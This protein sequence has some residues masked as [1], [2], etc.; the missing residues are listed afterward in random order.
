MTQIQH[1]I[2]NEL[3]KEIK[4]YNGWEGL[5]ENLD[6]LNQMSMNEIRNFLYDN[7]HHNFHFD[8]NQIESF[9]I[10]PS[11]KEMIKWIVNNLDNEKW[12]NWTRRFTM[13]DLI[14]KKLNRFR[15]RYE[16]FMKGDRVRIVKKRSGRFEDIEN[17][18]DKYYIDDPRWVIF[19]EIESVGKDHLMVQEK[20][21]RMNFKGEN[22][23]PIESSDLYHFVVDWTINKGEPRRIEDVYNIYSQ[24]QWLKMRTMDDAYDSRVSADDMLVK[25]DKLNFKYERYVLVHYIDKV[26]AYNTRLHAGHWSLFNTID[27]TRAG[28]GVLI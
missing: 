9:T 24:N 8:N 5:T 17:D 19:Y 15:R 16:K 14:N 21:C 27:E 25:V 3:F 13:K 22:R 4:E 18:N 1:W 28:F 2:P 12:H 20:Q 23:S 6:L 7:K 11:K 26:E 10:E